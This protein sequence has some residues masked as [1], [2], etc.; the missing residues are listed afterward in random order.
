MSAQ[1]VTDRRQ[2]ELWRHLEMVMDPELDESVVSMGFVEKA[3]IEADDSITVEF[4]LPTY[5]CSPNFVFLML[6][7]IRREMGRLSWQ[8]TYQIMLLDHVMGAEINTALAA[9]RKFDDIAGQLAPD[10]DIAE[11][12]EIFAMK[13]FK[14][15]QEAV[16]L[17]L[18]TLGIADQE[19]VALSGVALERLV[20]VYD[21][22]KNNVSRYREAF[23]RRFPEAL[24]NSSTFLT[25]EGELVPED[26]FQ[27]YLKKLRSVRINMEFNG[28][29]CRGLKQSRYQ[30]AVFDGDEPQ[31]ADFIQGAVPSRCKS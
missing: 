30:G 24:E 4:R 10:A 29:L 16:L 23:K 27:I 19:I 18:C 13:A 14:C 2:A 31:L 6:D 3:E 26:G 11:L 25:W 9:G 7:D 28:A 5:W 21:E 22:L 17:A 20:F 8:P 1:S 12:R 15:R